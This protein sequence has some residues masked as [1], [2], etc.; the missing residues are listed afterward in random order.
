VQGTFDA[1]TVVRAELTDG[2]GDLLEVLVPY[3][4]VRQNYHPVGET[5]GRNPPEVNNDLQQVLVRQAVE[6]ALQSLRQG[7]EEQV[8]SIGVGVR[9]GRHG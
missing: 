8:Q 4:L 9:N 2:P 7:A 3:R 6:H 5:G 1:G